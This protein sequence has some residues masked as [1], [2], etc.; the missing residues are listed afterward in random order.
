MSIAPSRSSSINRTACVLLPV[1][2]IEVHVKNVEDMRAYAD[3]GM[4]HSAFLP[5]GNAQI[6]MTDQLESPPAESYIAVHSA[7]MLLSLSNEYPNR[8]AR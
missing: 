3:V 5:A 7:A 8:S 4:K 1:C 6:R 2:S